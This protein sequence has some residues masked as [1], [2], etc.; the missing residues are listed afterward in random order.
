HGV[1]RGLRRGKVLA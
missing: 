1:Q